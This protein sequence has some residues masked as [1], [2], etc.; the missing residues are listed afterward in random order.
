MSLT[1]EHLRPVGFGLYGHVP[2]PPVSGGGADDRVEGKVGFDFAD[3]DGAGVAIHGAPNRSFELCVRESRSS[4]LPHRSPTRRDSNVRALRLGRVLRAEVVERF[5]DL[6]RAQTPRR[7]LRVTRTRVGA[8]KIRTNDLARDTEVVRDLLGP[9]D[10]RVLHTCMVH[11]RSN[12]VKRMNERI[13]RT[14]ERAVVVR[15]G[16]AFVMGVMTT[17]PST[18]MPGKLREGCGNVRSEAST[19]YHFRSKR[20]H[21]RRKERHA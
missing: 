3:E 14:F 12:E 9:G 10:L 21:I 6:L 15:V 18:P 16:N 8:A 13:S 17:P 4:R 7:T 1:N 2:L 19:P 5:A 11:E 20:C